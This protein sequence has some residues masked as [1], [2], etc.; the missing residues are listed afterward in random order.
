M[1]RKIDISHKTVFFI[2]AFLLALWVTYLIL[3]VILL[4]FVAFIF[5]SA[6]APLVERLIKLGLPR[7]VSVI[8]VMLL[9][10]S[11][12]IGLVT[13]GFTPLINQISNLS[14]RLADATASLLQTNLIDQSIL[15][16]E[17]GKV[18][19]QIISVSVSLLE[20]LIGF[21]SIIVITLYLL[22]DKPI[23]EDK[24]TSLFL[25]RRDQV[26]RTLQKIEEKLGAWLRGQIILSAIVGILYYIVLMVLGIEFALPLA[27]IGALLEVLPIIGP[28][29]SAIPAVLLG[30][31]VSPFLAA[32]V[33]GS[34]L[35][36]QQL[37]N[38]IIVPQVMKKAVGLNPILVILAVAI[39]GR[40]LGIEGALLAVPIA[41]VIQVVVEEVLRPEVG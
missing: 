40:L 10:L 3:D 32:L 31:T 28:I 6:L 36:I 21:V 26:K 34:Y 27:I 30:L 23:I 25:H 20:N 18:S 37:E 5:T 16:D 19:R 15:R 38:H 9:S 24:L 8:L 13:V 39:G 11:F 2:T 7:S 17:L 33:A 41:V 35:A 12:L 1:I 29:I 4:V 22:L 14:Q